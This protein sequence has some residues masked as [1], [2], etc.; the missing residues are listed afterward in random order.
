M[1][2]SEWIVAKIITATK[3]QV[4]GTDINANHFIG[5]TNAFVQRIYKVSIVR[6]EFWNNC[7]FRKFNLYNTFGDNFDYVNC[8]L[9][10]LE[11]SFTASLGFS[12]FSL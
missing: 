4:A 6:F 10:A 1:N 3:V 8:H 7:I 11:Y 12:R 9:K 5:T 2:R